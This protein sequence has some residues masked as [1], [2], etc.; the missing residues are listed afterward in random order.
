MFYA[1]IAN[2]NAFSRKKKHLNHVFFFVKSAKPS[3]NPH[4]NL[5]NSLNQLFRNR[6][7]TFDQ[8][9]ENL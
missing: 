1:N 4:S 5:Q 9:I 3:F 7:E 8:N 2:R 6:N